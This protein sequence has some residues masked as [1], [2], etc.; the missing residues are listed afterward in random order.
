MNDTVAVDAL[1]NGIVQVQM[2]DKLSKNC[3]TSSLV[4]G[5]I[6]AFATIAS[7]RSYKVVVLTGF[8]SYFCSGGTKE[9]LIDLVDGKV[10]FTDTQL[11][12]LPLDCPLPVLSAMQ[13][14]AIGGGFV[15]G[16][17]ADVV[18]LSRESIYAANFMKYGFTPGFGTTLVL[19]QKLG[20]ALAAEMML[21]A[22]TYRGEELQRRGVPFQVLPRNE[23]LQRAHELAATIAEKP[24]DALMALKAHIVAPLRENLAG[25]IAKELQMHAQTLHTREVRDRI[26]HAFD[27]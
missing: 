23:L 15:F 22:G 14:H 27:N 10:K 17:F 25:Y 6:E 3:F 2:K 26:E 7:S 12:R 4:A 5:L 8:D 16:L 1:G 24:R 11:Y 20:M 18:L 9:G 13:G 21:T 19:P